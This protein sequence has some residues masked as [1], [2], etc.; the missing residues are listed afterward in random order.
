MDALQALYNNHETFPAHVSIHRVIANSSKELLCQALDVLW[1]DASL[2]TLLDRKR[3]RL[4]HLVDLHRSLGVAVSDSQHQLICEAN[5]QSMVHRI[6]S[7]FDCKIT[8]FD[9]VTPYFNQENVVSYFQQQPD[10]LADVVVGFY[11]HRLLLPT[12]LVSLL[13]SISLDEQLR[14]RIVS[15]AWLYSDLA[16]YSA[17]APLTGFKMMF[18]QY[19]HDDF[20]LRVAAR[21]MKV[22]DELAIPEA[23]RL[24]FHVHEAVIERLSSTSEYNQAFQWIRTLHQLLSRP[25]C[26]ELLQYKGVD[27][28]VQSLFLDHLSLQPILRRYEDLWKTIYP[29]D[30]WKCIALQNY[31]RSHLQ[32]NQP[33]TALN[34]LET[35]FNKTATMLLLDF[36]WQKWT[37]RKRERAFQLVHQ[38]LSS[39]SSDVQLSPVQCTRLLHL[40]NAGMHKLIST[41]RYQDT[42]KAFE[43]CKSLVGTTMDSS[44]SRDGYVIQSLA[45]QAGYHLGLS[46]VSQ[47]N[48][49][50]ELRAK[51]SYALC[52]NGKSNASCTTF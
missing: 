49:S 22:L 36:D 9:D 16:T 6:Q 32:H 18:S 11:E 37:L 23:T 45:A 29:P 4:R 34:A 8:K 35:S 21:N 43:V 47:K 27:G 46:N 28:L 39:S 25:F 3:S 19:F 20:S 24:M 14:E 2:V 5:E 41:G 33:D 17:L 10:K 40:Y 51:L 44:P 52:S 30:N 1:K 12:P 50:I 26:S 38:Y 48:T 42:M 15:A 31:C 13:S 7:L